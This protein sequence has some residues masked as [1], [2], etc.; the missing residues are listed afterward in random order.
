MRVADEGDG[1]A[2]GPPGK[3]ALEAVIGRA[4]SSGRTREMRR[5]RQ[6]SSTKEIRFFVS[7]RTSLGSFL[8]QRRGYARGAQTATASYQ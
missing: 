4:R 8:L 6:N 1:T 7:I 3:I 5:R 2:R